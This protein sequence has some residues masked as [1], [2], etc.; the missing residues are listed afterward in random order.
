MF[1]PSALTHELVDARSAD[2][3]RRARRIRL[4]RP[5]RRPAVR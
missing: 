5:R 4:A 2:V 3:V 1:Q